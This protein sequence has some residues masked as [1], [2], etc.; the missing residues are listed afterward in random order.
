MPIFR[1]SAPTATRSP[2]AVICSLIGLAFLLFAAQWLPAPAQPIPPVVKTI[3]RAT[4]DSAD[5]SHPISVTAQLPSGGYPIRTARVTLKF[6]DAPLAHRGG[7]AWGYTVNF[8]LTP[9]NGTPV[10]SALTINRGMDR[11]AFEAV[12]VLA[13]FP[14]DSTTLTV[15]G[16]SSPDK[17][18]VP[19]QITLELK[20]T[21]EVDLA[22][23]PT[24]TPSVTFHSDA[25]TI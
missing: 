19:D 5:A 17:N 16:T 9:G 2:G 20:L 13:P 15:T 22:L 24:K 12:A 14:S 25:N 8:S 21:D 23:D 4:L 11:E 3:D 6:N 1:L 18:S 7:A 10:T